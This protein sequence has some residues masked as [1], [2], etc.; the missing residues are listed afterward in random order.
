MSD[1][2]EDSKGS[3]SP[4]IGA[5]ALVA[6]AVAGGV[7]YA[8]WRQHELKDIYYV[9]AV[10]PAPHENNVAVFASKTSV[11]QDKP[12]PLEYFLAES[13]AIGKLGFLDC[14]K[15]TVR[16]M[17]DGNLVDGSL[18]WSTSKIEEV[19]CPEG[20]FPDEIRRGLFE[21]GIVPN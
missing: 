6:A 12:Q 16:G 1:L 5:F 14:F 19:S 10:L 2:N 11:L 8:A 17:A 13:E 21:A 7:Y 9:N 18:Q 20:S 3:Y 4:L 15:A